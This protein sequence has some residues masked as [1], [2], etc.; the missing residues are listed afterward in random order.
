MNNESK[1]N[2]EGKKIVFLSLIF[3]IIAGWAY[4]DWGG[5][6]HISLILIVVGAIDSPLKTSYRFI[7]KLCTSAT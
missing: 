6:M 7:K 3:G 2:S 5:G 1:M 4:E